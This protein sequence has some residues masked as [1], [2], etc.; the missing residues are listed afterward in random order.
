MPIAQ[1]PLEFQG[2][3]DSHESPHIL[4]ASEWRHHHLW[5]HYAAGRSAHASLLQEV[6]RPLEYLA[7]L[8]KAPARSDYLF[9]AADRVL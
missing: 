9:M 4:S 5:R 8:F 1:S 2:L 3:L 6:R 7:A